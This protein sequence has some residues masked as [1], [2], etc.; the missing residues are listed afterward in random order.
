MPRKPGDGLGTRNLKDTTANLYGE[1]QMDNKVCEG[2]CVKETDCPCP[3]AC[4]LPDTDLSFKE[5]YLGT[6]VFVVST[7]TLALVIFSF[8]LGV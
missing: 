1:I 3:Q 2:K 4:G 5:K 6:I 7:L 8:I